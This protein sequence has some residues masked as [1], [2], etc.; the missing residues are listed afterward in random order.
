[1]GDY[2]WAGAYGTYFWIDPQEK[3]FAVLMTQMPFQQSGYYRRAMRELVYG[4]LEH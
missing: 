4:A 1:V 2:F 3:M